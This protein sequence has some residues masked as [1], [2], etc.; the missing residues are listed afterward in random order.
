MDE[1]GDQLSGV[2]RYQTARFDA[3]TIEALQA[4]FEALLRAIVERPETPVVS[5]LPEPR[6]KAERAVAS[7]HSAPASGSPPADGLELKLQKIWSDVLRL[8]S[9]EPEADFF[10][11]SGHSL[12][13]AELVSTMTTQLGYPVPPL[14]VLQ[15]PTVRQLAQALHQHDGVSAWSSLV[16]IQASGARPPLFLIH[17]VG[18]NIFIYRDLAKHL[19][20]EQPV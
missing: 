17:A 8:K 4:D 12:L 9:V 1:D 11:L 14:I 2:W 18:G 20:P 16:P 5:L 7:S 10:A 19:G 15:A 6:L 13:A 3:H